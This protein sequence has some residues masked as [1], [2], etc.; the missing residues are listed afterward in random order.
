M[1]PYPRKVQTLKTEPHCART[2]LPYRFASTERRSPRA[3]Q[4]EPEKSER[5]SHRN[6]PSSKN[7]SRLNPAFHQT[8]SLD[9]RGT[10]PAGKR[11]PG[12]VRL[13]VCILTQ[14]HIVKRRR[15][16]SHQHCPKKESSRSQ[17]RNPKTADL[18]AQSLTTEDV[19]KGT[20]R[21]NERGHVRTRMSQEE[22]NTLTQPKARM[23]KEDHN[24]M[25]TCTNRQTVESRVVPSKGDSEASPQRIVTP[26]WSIQ[27]ISIMH[28]K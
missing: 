1:P 9:P 26:R 22:E 27:L 14:D 2:R 12:S 20:G 19:T 6:D 21:N 8:W 25:P 16:C 23:A 15:T 24:Q 17:S 11:A 4:E 18:H 10:P 13:A 28:E 3:D 7:T 5:Q